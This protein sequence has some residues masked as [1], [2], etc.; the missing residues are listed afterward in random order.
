VSRK[1]RREQAAHGPGHRAAV[2]SHDAPAG[3]LS[4]GQRQR[5]GIA[6]ALVT[7][8]SLLLADET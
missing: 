6:R 5:V 1:E 3:E 8:P 4:G 7:Q 2:R